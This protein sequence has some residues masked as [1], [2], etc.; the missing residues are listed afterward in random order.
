MS[1]DKL[2]RLG[3]QIRSLWWNIPSCIC[4]LLA[5]V[6]VCGGVGKLFPREVEGVSPKLRSFRAQK[7]KFEVVFLGSSRM[8]HGISP[9]VFDETTRAT[10]HRWQSFNAG[11]DGL[12]TPE[13]FAISRRLLLDH[14]HKLRY[15]FFELTP[16]TGAGTPLRDDSV[17]KRDVYWRD[18]KSLT[19][20]FRIFGL[21]LTLADPNLPG[22]RFSFQRWSFFGPLLS[23]NF[24]L[25]ARN[26]AN[27]GVGFELNRALPFWMSRPEDD[28]VP[29]AWDGFF[30]L[31]QP[32]QGK[33]MADYQAALEKARRETKTPPPD[34][35]MRRE[36]AEFCRTLAKKKIEVIFIVLPSLWWGRGVRA[37]APAGQM[38]LS[39]DDYTRHPEFYEE[40]N[41]LD[42]EHLNA[43]G[44]DL[45]SRTLANDFVAMLNRGHSLGA[46]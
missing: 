5:F 14:P 18:W 36:L 43:R 22:A 30:P 28:Q 31:S 33:T 12:S 42:V 32:M 21:G 37:T 41:R 23:A 19:S 45:F 44:A 7:D 20:A 6:L 3:P 25:W 16:R 27:V 15:L 13:G 4:V 34:E 10:G 2:S 8:F 1:D 11:F 9:K 40:Q 26:E 24:R 35:I 29:P 46:P 17:T 38:V 39:Y